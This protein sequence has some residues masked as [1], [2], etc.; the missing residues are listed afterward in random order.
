[1]SPLQESFLLWAGSAIFIMAVLVL[2]ATWHFNVLIQVGIVLV[3]I[4][5]VWAGLFLGLDIG[6]REWQRMPDP[7]DEAFADTAPLGMLLAGWLPGG[8]ITI[9][10]WALLK[11]IEFG[12]LA[13]RGRSES[14]LNG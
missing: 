9:T 2:V 7:P 4:I 14:R 5:I 3:G 11:L 10:W 13:L 8:M 6:Y 1:M 12:L